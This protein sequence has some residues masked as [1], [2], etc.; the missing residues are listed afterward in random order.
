MANGCWN[1]FQQMMWL[2]SNGTESRS[3]W[4]ILYQV[5]RFKMNETQLFFTHTS[6]KPVSLAGRLYFTSDLGSHSQWHKWMFRP[7][8]VTNISSIP[9][10][11]NQLHYPSP[12]HQLTPHLLSREDWA[13]SI[14]ARTSGQEIPQQHKPFAT[15]SPIITILNLQAVSAWG[16]KI[17]PTILASSQHEVIHFWNDNPLQADFASLLQ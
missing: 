16:I 17:L 5:P 14:G 2:K 15:V 1:G 9:C 12:K 7:L 13:W 8:F 11:W 6:S 4:V 3:L 10:G